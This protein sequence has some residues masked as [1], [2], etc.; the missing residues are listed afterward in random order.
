MSE[1][2]K[3]IK[4]YGFIAKHGEVELRLRL[5][6]LYGNEPKLGLRAWVNDYG[7]GGMVL[8][9][10]QLVNLK[11]LIDDNSELINSYGS[12]KNEE[13]SEYVEASQQITK[14]LN[15]NNSKSLEQMIEAQ[16]EKPK[17]KRGR[18]PK[19]KVEEGV[20]EPAESG[21][22]NDIVEKLATLSVSDPEYMKTIAHAK[23]EE[24]D[25]AIKIMNGKK[26]VAKT[27]AKAEA[28]GKRGRKAKESKPAGKKA[29]VIQFPKPKPE[30]KHKLVTDGN[31][32]YEGGGAKINKEGGRLKDSVGGM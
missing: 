14:E 16:A 4:D 13:V 5:V 21:I 27:V 22:N 25:M 30:L 29:D 20:E 12:E 15:K 8:T 2:C 24:I 18:P 11:K 19:E 17:K 10:E 31:A 7:K 3:I 28:N 6:S 32:T 9:K 23:P 1:D 26:K